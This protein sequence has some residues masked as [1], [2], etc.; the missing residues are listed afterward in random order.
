MQC[1]R[2][3]CVL[4]FCAGVL[5]CDANLPSLAHRRDPGVLVVAQA[6][7][8][9]GLDP[10]RVVDTESIE[11]G[12]I[13]FEGLTRWQPGTADVGPGLA[14]A[15]Q[16]SDDGLHWTFDLR[17][18][19]VFHDGTT[20]DADAVVFSFQRVID[21]KHP[22]YLGDDDASYWRGRMKDVWRVTAL[23]PARV[24]IEVA[25]PYAPLLGDLAMFPIVS[26]A[27]VRR[28][29]TEFWRH[30]I[31]TGAFAFVVWEPGEQ[32]VVRRFERYWGERPTLERI[33]FRVV[34]DAR[35]RLVDLQSGS[36]DIAAA[37]LPEEQLFVE[38]HPDLNLLYAPTNDVSYLAFNTMHPPFDDR[39]VR[40]AINHAINK[41]P[42]V[43][44]A[45]QGHA[46]VADGPLPPG[47]WGYHAPGTRYPYDP[48]IAKQLLDAAIAAH[49]FDPDRVYKLVASRTPRPYLVEPERVARY[50]QTAL[51]EIGVKTELVLLSIAAYREAVR[52]GEHDLA[53]GGWMGDTGDPDNFFYALL[54]SDNA[55]PRSAHNF[56]FYRN[57]SVDALLSSARAATDR[58]SREALYAEVQ[59][60]IAADAPWV[61]I[62]H[63]KLVVAARAELD[64]VILSPLGHLLY[65]RIYR[66][67]P[68]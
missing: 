9:T 21:P 48:V 2:C 57:P 67:G 10:V 59:D 27:A 55:V 52:N 37:I 11:V 17:P 4:V 65:S 62:A 3:P 5:A 12:G 30:P 63:S 38:L 15:W 36:V 50:L 28:W 1:A 8:V 7:D 49:V 18:S 43:R 24:E 23:G 56:A 29:G 47:Q 51:S 35:Q 13:L 25:H 42:I 32:V 34:I 66:K 54:H 61:P 60:R 44:L 14:T 22:S 26:P 19:V 33:V 45:Y 6:A 31:G 46:K 16:V 39:G 40:R 68:R 20:L 64:G 53:L 58:S 41:E